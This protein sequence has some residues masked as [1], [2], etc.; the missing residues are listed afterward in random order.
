MVKKRNKEENKLDFDYQQIFE[1]SPQAIVV[2]SKTGKFLQANNRIYDWLGYKPKDLIGKNILKTPFFPIASKKGITIKFSDR[3]RGK[4]IDPYIVK[5][6]SKNK[7]EKYGKIIGTPIRDKKGKIIADLVMITDVTKEHALELKLGKSQSEKGKLETKVKK[8]V[9]EVYD[10]QVF[11]NNVIEQSPISTCITDE[12]GTSIRINK[13]CQKFFKIKNLKEVIGKYNLFE[14]NI[15]RKNR[16]ISKIRSVY[17]EGKV[18]NFQIDRH[19]ELNDSKCALKEKKIL[20]DVTIFPIKDSRGKITNAV[21]QYR[22]I[23]ENKQ[24]EDKIK[25]SEKLLKIFLNNSPTVFF[26]KDLQGNYLLVNNM[27][28]QLFH[29]SNKKIIDKTDYDIFPKEMADAFRKNDLKVIKSKSPLTMDEEA[30]QDDGVH[31]YSSIKFPIFDDNKNV[32]AV[33]GIAVDITK[34]RISQNQLKKAKEEANLYFDVAGTMLIFVDQKGIV[35]K[36]NRKGL[37]ILKYPEKEV[38]N[39]D[40]AVNFLPKRSRREGEEFCKKILAGKIDTNEYSENLILT[41]KGKERLI[42][43]YRSIIRNEEGKIIGCLSS[44]EDITQR[45]KIEKQARRREELL[46]SVSFIAQ[47]LLK[48]NEWSEKIQTV[49]GVLGKSIDVSRVY[50]FRNFKDKNKKFSATQ[51]NEWVADGVDSELNNSELI[52][53]FYKKN[54][55]GRWLKILPHE[56]I[57][58]GNIKNFPKKEK[59]FL[60][61]QGIKS[62]FIMPIFVDDTWWGF[63]GFDECRQERQWSKVEIFVLRIIRQLIESSLKQEIFSESLEKELLGSEKMNELMIGRELKMVELKEKI[64]KLKNKIK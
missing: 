25:E 61:K 29:V 45:R 10:S 22:D 11:L 13:S 59:I 12:K 6:I 8:R 56:D 24:A 43:W 21:V 36:I 42:S 31:T 15:L 50:I 9:K 7:K 32:I 27:F 60:K 57:I 28:E 53:F 35:K 52:H 63:I 37:E 1:L 55:F 30:M 48:A 51:I 44:G 17:K 14:D 58:I 34:E 3:I 47:E 20:V 19:F 62:I 16:L 5:F 38:L 49:L 2:L 41:K 54:G 40:W 64:K 33:A 26:M 46:E 4:K 39:K 18:I 23:T